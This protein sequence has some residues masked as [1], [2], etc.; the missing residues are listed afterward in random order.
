MTYTM[1]NYWKTAASIGALLVWV[2]AP[3]ASVRADQSPFA[4]ACNRN[5]SLTAYTFDMNVVVAMR[6]FPWLHFRLAGAGQNVRGERYMVRF[7]KTPFFA[8]GFNK[9]DLSAL[10]PRMW[11]KQYDVSLV[12]QK[13]SMT[14]F[15]LRP[16]DEG[17]DQKNSLKD[18]LVTL[19][20]NYA[21]RT[22]VLEYDDGGNIT[23][24]LTPANT[25]GYWLPVTGEA[26]IDMPGEVLT[27]HA[28][29][30]DYAIETSQ[31]IASSPT[32]YNDAPKPEGTEDRESSFEHA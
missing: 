3:S 6:H 9:I 25:N 1:G 26:Q 14:T 13:N 21:T 10:D 7:T 16:L 2:I 12:D 5:P 30:T 27:A 4:L 17:Q 22:V 28:S 19:D 32:N 8:K 24:N 11:K 29:F 31:A 18:A 23:F 15:S 20:A